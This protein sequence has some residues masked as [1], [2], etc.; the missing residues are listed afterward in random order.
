MTR[1]AVRP[2]PP[3]TGTGRT[4]T[5]ARSTTTRTGAGSSYPDWLSWDE[6]TVDANPALASELA[7]YSCDWCGFTDR[8]AEFRVHGPWQAANDVCAECIGDCVA[9]AVRSERA[10]TVETT[11]TY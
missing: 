9:T 10:V 11:T 8:A 2:A 3:L 6:V 4:E 1:A 5:T 7:S